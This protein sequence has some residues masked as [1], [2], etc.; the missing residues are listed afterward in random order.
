MDK[1]PAVA[2]ITSVYN[3]EKHLGEAIESV[4][5]QTFSDFEYII[6]DDASTDGTWNILQFFA[7]KDSRL[8]IFRNQQNRER[9]FSRNKAIEEARAELIA[10]FD[11]DDVCL[12]DRLEKQ[13]S[14]MEGH[15]E[16][17]V[18][19]GFYFILESG[20][21]IPQ[22]TSNEKIRAALPFANSLTHSAIIYRKSAVQRVGGYTCESVPV[23][24]YD[25]WSRLSYEQDIIFA[26]LTEPVMYYRTDESR[27]GY[28]DPQK[29]D[30][31]LH[32]RKRSLLKLGLECSAYQ[33]QAHSQCIGLQQISSYRQFFEAKTWLLDILI[34]NFKTKLYDNDALMDQVSSCVK[35]LESSLL[36]YEKTKN[37]VEKFY[38]EYLRPILSYGKSRLKSF[39]RL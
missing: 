13:V 6:V 19:G 4:L 36:N 20:Q 8:R 14:F 38:E 27:K 35:N 12:P 21:L 29:P 28:Q 1:T 24:D 31:T 2:V 18:Y 32:I 17:S 34:A 22:Y 30:Y 3:G 39:V 10:V 9:A 16:V 11:A 26:N 37:S 25:L 23:E 33:I 15:P 7:E 5:A